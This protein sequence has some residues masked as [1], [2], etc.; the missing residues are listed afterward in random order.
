MTH[1]YACSSIKM[2]SYQLVF[3]IVPPMIA[4]FT[5]VVDDAEEEE[6]GGEIDTTES[7]ESPA[8][9]ASSSAHL[10]RY[11]AAA[12]ITAIYQHNWEAHANRGVFDKVLV[13][14]FRSKS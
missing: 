2:S 8:A 1:E 13:T 6:G 14:S 10:D 7:N 4:S 11:Q 3:G 9:A 12:V 5:V